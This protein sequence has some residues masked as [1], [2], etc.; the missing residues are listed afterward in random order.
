MSLLNLLSLAI[1]NLRTRAIRPRRPHRTGLGRGEHLTIMT[2]RRRFPPKFP[3]YRRKY[4]RGHIWAIFN[5]Q[6]RLCANRQAL[7]SIVYAFSF[8]R[9][10]GV[11]WPKI[12]TLGTH[13]QPSQHSQHIAEAIQSPRDEDEVIMESNALLLLRNQLLLDLSLP[14]RCQKANKLRMMSR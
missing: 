2:R 11:Q 12:G 5:R 7:A 10:T 9:G 6:Y 8:G 13:T 3:L 1:C 14:G 4:P